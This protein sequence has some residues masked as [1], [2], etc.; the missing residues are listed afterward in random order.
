[1]SSCV[2]IVKLITIVLQILVLLDVSPDQ[3]MLDEGVAREIVN[4][5]QKLRKKAHLVPTDEVTVYYQ[6]TPAT[7]DLHRIA[8]THIEYVEGVI[9]MPFRSLQGGQLQNIIIEEKQQVSIRK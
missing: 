3:S 2:I 7:S 8:S 6:V 4:R 9:K 5:I 1:M